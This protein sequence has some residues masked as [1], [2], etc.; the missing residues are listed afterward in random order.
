MCVCTSV[1]GIQT[2]EPKVAVLLLDKNLEFPEDRVHLFHRIS[3]TVVSW[4]PCNQVCER[5]FI[6][7]FVLH[8]CPS[9]TLPSFISSA[10]GRRQPTQPKMV[11]AF[12][13]TFV[14]WFLLNL[15][16]PA[17]AATR[18]WC[19]QWSFHTHTINRHLW[20]WQ[21]FHDS[22]GFNPARRQPKVHST[23]Q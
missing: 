14:I 22:N 1:A 17:T 23:D 7:L 16:I 8:I 15:H 2:T 10:H 6:F 4:I 20:F 21:T 3:L 9:S 13:S 18:S 11:A 12:P 19:N 5:I